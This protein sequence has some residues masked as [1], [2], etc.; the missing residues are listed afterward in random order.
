M[1]NYKSIEEEIAS[2]YR[3]DSRRSAARHLLEIPNWVEILQS[4]GATAEA[5]NAFGVLA[6]RSEELNNVAHAQQVKLEA[7]FQQASQLFFR[8]NVEYENAISKT[9]VL[10]AV[11]ALTGD[12]ARARSMVLRSADHGR[13]CA[14]NLQ[15]KLQDI[16][17]QAAIGILMLESDNW[18]GKD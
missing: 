7:V 10:G 11:V 15:D 1:G 2:A 12:C 5:E 3:E 13:G 4:G 18:E 8:K 14:D 6:K 16:L 9:G 17:L